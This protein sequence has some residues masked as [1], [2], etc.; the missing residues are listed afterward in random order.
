MANNLDQDQIR[1]PK[2]RKSK[3]NP[4]TIGYDKNQKSYFLNFPNASGIVQQ[5]YIGQE[6]YET[7]NGFELEDLAQLNEQER[8]IDGTELT[9]EYLYQKLTVLP[10]EVEEAI[11]R[12]LCAETIQKAIKT[13]S[14]TQRRRLILYYFEGLTYE[15]IAKI[16]GCKY[17]SVQDAIKLAEEKIK[18][19][20]LK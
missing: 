12:K 19:Y 3:D 6:L 16:E 1:F 11:D 4:Y 2:R 13:L 18:K 20:F 8:H 17:Q 5:I 9:E 7:F 15:Q 14:P 10:N